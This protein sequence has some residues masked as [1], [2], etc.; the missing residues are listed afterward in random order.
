MIMF[1]KISGI[2]LTFLFCQINYK[3]LHVVYNRLVKTKVV[4]SIGINVRLNVLQLQT[5]FHLKPLY[6][7]IFYYLEENKLKMYRWKLLQSILPTK[8][9]LFRW[10]VTY[11]D[12]CNKCFTEE[13]YQHYFMSC[14]F[15][16]DFLDI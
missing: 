14:S 6:N 4:K 2:I 11:N 16:H 10:K 5:E 15:L 12:L 3:L 9:L 13:D 1:V 7:F 8:K